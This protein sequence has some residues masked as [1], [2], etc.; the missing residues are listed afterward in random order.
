VQFFLT[1]HFRPFFLLL[2]K[3]FQSHTGTGI[4]TDSANANVPP[5]HSYPY[6]ILSPIADDATIPTYATLMTAQKQLNSNAGSVFSTEGTALHGHLVLTA[7]PARYLQ[8]TNNI[9]H[10][11]PVYPAPLQIGFGADPAD[12]AVQHRA[13]A[14]A[15]SIFRLYY[16]TDNALR[17]QLIAACPNR[18]INALNDPEFGYNNVTTL[19]LLTHLW[20]TYGRITSSDLDENDKRLNKAW[21]P[22]TPIETLF[23]QL[24]DAAIFATA[25][26]MP[27]GD[28]NIVRAG[29]NLIYATGVFEAACR[30]WR[31]LPIAGQTLVAFRAHFT[32][33]D[34]DRA[35]T[36]SSAGYHSANAVAAT[37]LSDK[38]AAIKKANANL[39]KEIK[40]LRLSSS[41]GLIATTADDQGN[42]YCW[43]HGTS[44]NK[45]HSSVTCHHK[46]LGHQDSATSTNKMGGSEK[47]WTAA[48]SK[49]SK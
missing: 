24:D 22:P 5:A 39:E 16:T 11:V 34:R 28:G 36:T 35:A 18:F 26:G 31:L 46:A 7:Q 45:K 14:L 17:Q 2:K 4:M 49:F 8:L 32:I 15:A 30:D 43:T 6:P 21:H 42:T 41:S 1:A 29:Y 10:P 3:A 20:N 38:L 9:V 48:D 33:A 40:Q 37:D 25:G 23:T 27:I 19:Q 12:V 47:I 13:F 44:S